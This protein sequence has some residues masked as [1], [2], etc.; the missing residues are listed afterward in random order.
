MS[1]RRA[2]LQAVLLTP[3]ALALRT[4]SAEAT[5]Y[6]SAA[7]VFEAIDRLEAD[8]AARLRRLGRQSPAARAFTASALAD[9]ERHRRV[10]AR[11]R[12]RLRLGAA[13]VATALVE[14]E[15]ASLAHL[16]AAQEALVYAHAEGFPALGDAFAVRD[17]MANMVDL[18]RHLSV[19]DL[20]IERE[21]AGG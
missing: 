13:T 10:R 15:A 18:A 21:E 6:A 8:A 9:H 16:R 2:L 19:I 12:A 11:H 17:L 20:W 4:A 1:E 7:E 14:S 3:L 5:D